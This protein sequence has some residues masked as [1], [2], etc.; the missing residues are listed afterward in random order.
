[1][2]RFLFILAGFL[3]LCPVLRAQSTRVR[4]RVTDASTGMPI[5]FASVM[6]AGTV[7]GIT[8]DTEGFYTLE[9]RDTASLVQVFVL[10]Y[11]ELTR[12]VHRNAFNQVDFALQPVEF[13]IE[14]VVVTPGA[15]PAFPIL[16]GVQRH[17]PR[18]DPDRME[19]YSYRTYTKM[20]LDLANVKPRFRSKKLQRNFGFIFEHLDT[21]VVTGQTFLPAMISE[22]TADYYHSKHPPLARE[23]IRASR[24][25]GVDDSFSV[26]QFT[27]HLHANVNF[28]D[29][30][31]DVFNVQFASPLSASGQSYYHYFL[32][33]STAQK[34]RKTYT[35]RF[36]PR[37]T[38]TPVLDGEVRIDSATYALM[39][40]HVKMARGVN[41]NWI[42][43]LVLENENRL[44]SDSLWFRSRDKIAAEF[45]V[46]YADSSK[47]VSFLGSRE[48]VYTDVQLGQPIPEEILR[49]DNNV[50]LDEGV[51]RHEE[52]YW[53]TIRPYALSEKEKNIYRMV[54]SIQHVPLY[55]NIYT[56]INTII[57]G[58]YNTKYIGFG[59]YYKFLSFNDQEGIRLQ[60][61]ARTT[62]AFS[63]RVR[64]SGYAAYGFKDTGVKGGAG[65]EVVFN[66]RLTRKLDL[67]YRHDM[68]QLGA[69]DHAL[70][71]S[72]ILSSILARGN[73]ERLSMVDRL[74]AEYEH[75]WRHGISN[76]LGLQSMHILPNPRVPMIRPDGR[77][78]QA[79]D[80]HTLRAGMRLS[81]DENIVRTVFDKHYMGS[82]YPVL[83]FAATGAV[84]GITR[85]DY[86]YF[87][88]DAGIRYDLELPPIG[89]S[90]LYVAG[91]KIFGKVPYLLLK[92]HEGNGTYF[93]DPYAFS[94]MNF[95]EF[96]SDQWVSFFYE[97]HFN[98]FILGKIPLLKKLHWRMVYVLKGVHGTLAARNNGSLPST[99]AYLYFPQ[100]M[101]SVRR[102]YIETGF[103]VEN[104]FRLLRVD[105]IWR[106]TH[107]GP[108]PGQRIQD[109][110]VNFSLRLQF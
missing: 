65:V 77:P 15:N 102:P 24:I 68:L 13:G 27:G 20:E 97:H 25:S 8:T 91:G 4:G 39:S 57:G 93:H 96:A 35:I 62:T 86:K 14:Q 53:D 58:Y 70:S 21:S 31:I 2:R 101:S 55:R 10:G 19:R 61:G 7:T 83:S 37:S 23:V 110:A 88:L 78:V 108:D 9:T 41:V 29:N 52:A 11:E 99:Q 48:V 45:S 104:I 80:A 98:G 49:M 38:S 105:C 43:H 63:K 3:L 18:N 103:G 84:K 90:E 85:N 67:D 12:S 33:D 59:P 50:V 22:A 73:R 79:V 76:T 44:V 100:G 36:H 107:R 32:V 81:F 6:F 106:L 54:D 5:P 66:R 17:K 74:R 30:F 75:E 82:R 28:Y 71:E 87:R 64:L 16:E 95:Y 1:M 51:N 69:G 94:C 46:A 72:N 109:F 26:A 92:L 34:G 60:A 42:R 89:R 40:A 47:L 56:V